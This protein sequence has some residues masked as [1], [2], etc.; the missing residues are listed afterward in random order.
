MP[1]PR[2]CIILLNYNRCQDTIACIESLRR[3]HDAPFQILIVDNASADQ[4]E[5]I[6]RNRFPDIV[7]AQT[8]KNLGYTGGINFGIR[9]ARHMQPEYLLLLNNDTL[10][11]PDFL[12]HLVEAL[13]QNR[14]AAAAGGTIYCEHDRQ[15]IWYAGGQLIPWRGLAVHEQKGA[16]VARAALNGV[17]RVSFITGCMILLRASL[18]DEIGGEDERFFMYLDDIEFSARIQAKGYDMLYVPRATIYHKVWG[19]K[20]SAFKLYYSVRNRL[21]LINMAFGGLSRWIAGG[22][23][24][25]VIGCKL[26][27]WRFTNRPFFKAATYGLQDYFAQRFYEGRGVSEFAQ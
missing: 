14:G 15:Q 11:E 16:T 24:S 20:E 7:V 6:L 23:F 18:L 5:E 13:Q 4:S 2:V 8:G 25:L 27:I 1:H 10:V 3:C 21:L 26:V 12:H 22:Y 19:E 9:R 17:R